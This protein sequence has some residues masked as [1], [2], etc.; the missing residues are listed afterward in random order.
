MKYINVNKY[1]YIACVQSLMK[2]IN[3]D[4]KNKIY[5]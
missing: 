3:D 5:L 2:Y 1:V 4:D